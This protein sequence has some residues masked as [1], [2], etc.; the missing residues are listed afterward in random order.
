[1]GSEWRSSRYKQWE[2]VENKDIP[3]LQFIFFL[4]EILKKENIS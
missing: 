1:L 3:K 2:M 4:L